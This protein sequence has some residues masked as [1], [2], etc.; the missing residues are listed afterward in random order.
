MANPA[1]LSPLSSPLQW[2]VKRSH[3]HAATVVASDE[4]LHPVLCS[5]VP[6][7]LLVHFCGWNREVLRFEL[8]QVLRN[9]VCVDLAA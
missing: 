4:S 3:T 1:E 9:P 7:R 6:R 5:S 2:F 8:D